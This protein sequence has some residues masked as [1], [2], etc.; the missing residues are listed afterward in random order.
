MTITAFPSLEQFNDIHY[1][2]TSIYDQPTLIYRPKIKLHGAC[3]GVRITPAGDV[4]FQTKRID[5]SADKD[6][7][8]V[9]RILGTEA[10]IWSTAATDDIIT[11]FG[12]WAGPGVA[13]GDAIQQT[14][15]KRF[16]VFAVGFGHEADPE[17]PEKMLP[18]W[19]ITHPDA[20][21]EF[22]PEGIDRDI[23]RVL[24]Y[25][26]DALTFDF[27]DE[28]QVEAELTMLNELVAAVETKDPYVAR[29]FGIDH[30]GEG[31]VCVPISDDIGQ[32]SG[33]QYARLTFKTKTAKHRVRKQGKP[34]TIREPLPQSAQDF[35]ET[36]CTEAR[37]EQALHEVCRG[38]ADR[39]LTG[40]VIA[41][42]T[43]DIEKEAQREIEALPVSFDQV[44]P[45]ISQ[46]TRDWFLGKAQGIDKAA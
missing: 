15:R 38:R 46:I 45:Q 24:P 16:F 31:Y 33:K 32:I 43:A 13:R 34:A 17:N 6:L 12:E 44:K 25:E 28:A 39:K 42:M 21:E 10:D 14:D 18:R 26:G 3:L 9:V 29:E 20:I 1:R 4:T 7:D 37:L 11:F 5:L 22:M 27:S 2:A 19:M 8:N 30:P 23:V 35:V 40:K 41:W 36:F